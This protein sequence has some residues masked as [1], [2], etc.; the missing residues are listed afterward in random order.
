MEYLD[1]YAYYFLTFSFSIT[2]SWIY[3]K[4]AALNLKKINKFIFALLII[5]P[6]IVLQG[7]RYRVGTDYMSYA[8]LS[9]K[10]AESSQ[11]YISWYINEPL[12]IILSRFSYSISGGNPYFF[13][14]VDAIIQN[15]ILFKIADYYKN[16]IS[17]PILYTLY[18]GLCFPYFLNT[19]RQGLAVLIIWYSLRY[20]DE[21]KFMKFLI[22]LAT[23]T[24]IH[25]TAIVCIV[26][27]FFDALQR[28]STKKSIKKAII[29]LMSLSPLFINMFINILKR[30]QFFQKYLGYLGNGSTESANINFLFSFAMGACLFLLYFKQL[31][32][33]REF[34]RWIFLLELQLLSYLLTGYMAWSF[35]MGY[36]FYFGIFF[37]FASVEKKLS[38]PFNKVILFVIVIAFSLFNFTYKFYIQ[39]NC[40]IFPYQFVWNR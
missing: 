25:N 16:E 4:K 39:G 6:V 3:G 32:K 31:K 2:A 29:F 34:T 14:L 30:I 35:R 33:I 13:F 18:Y 21:G 1:S 36:Y 23:A 9:Q 28:S 38:K 7:F 5:L 26:F 10:F 12:F 27:Y 40:D 37:A 20:V 17:L 22:C 19:E 8:S 15:I 24:L 11:S